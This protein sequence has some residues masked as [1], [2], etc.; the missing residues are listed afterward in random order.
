V[1]RRQRAARPAGA[2]GERIAAAIPGVLAR[3][4]IASRL[5]DLASAARRPA[6]MGADFQRFVAEFRDRWV[7]IARA[8]NIV[9]S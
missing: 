2:A 7:A 4:E 6:P 9:A 3:P 8:E 5:D 1:D